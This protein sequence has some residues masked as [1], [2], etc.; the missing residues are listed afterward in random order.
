MAQREVDAASWRG[1][2]SPRLS[3]RG[4]LAA[5]GIA[6]GATGSGGLSWLLAGCGQQPQAGAAADAVGSVGW[7]RSQRLHHLVNFANW[8]DYIDVLDGKHPTLEHFTDL[9]GIAV[10]YSEP[11][12]ENLPFFASIKPS[13]EQKQF[14]GYDIIVTTNNSPALREL[15]TNNWLT[16]LDQSMMINFATYASP[17]VRNPPWDP[18]NVY[19]M[20]WQS[21]WTAIGY[22]S[23]VIKNP[24]DS[25][26][27]LF[28]QKY[29]GRVGMMSDP[30]EL[31]SVGLLAIGVD[32][33]TSTEADWRDAAALLQKQKSAGIV[34][35]YYDQN[36]IDNLKTGEIVVSQA[37]SGDIFQANL[38]QQY[39]DLKL[40]MPVEGAM[41]WTDNMCIP[42]YAQNP[43]DAMTLMDYFY[44][45]QIEAVVEYYNDYVCPV[46]AA[47]QVLLDPTGWAAQVLTSMRPE[48]GRPPSYT[49]DSL[50]VFPT[51]EYQLRSKD[52]YQFRN[53]AELALWNSLF[54][55]IAASS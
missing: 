4:L 11:V 25:V 14:T 54:E 49:A 6:V 13:L 41:F 18:G 23:S 8:P 55:P 21:G 45:P 37:F 32:P 27:I 48:I 30:Y 52:Y 16:P 47:R 53:A 28:D 51:Q 5:T 1:L 19:T 50:L 3:R 7:W 44:Q 40:L 43:R 42:M 29:A 9:T 15:I 17:L 12:S 31:G 10:N 38:Q 39:R 22:N 26:G 34:R 33:A 24:G 46:P 20:A 36:Y 35:G 2:T